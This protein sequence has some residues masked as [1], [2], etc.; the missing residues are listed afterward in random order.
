MLGKA[1]YE[2][3]YF[4][5]RVSTKKLYTFKMIQKI[6]AAYLEFHT[7]TDLPFMFWLVYNFLTVRYLL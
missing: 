6:N 1:T 2:P 5:Y 4:L 3:L 7:V